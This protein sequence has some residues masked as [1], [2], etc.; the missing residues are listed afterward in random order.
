[1]K[2]DL[3]AVGQLIVTLILMGFAIVFMFKFP[4]HASTAV[5]FVGLLVIWDFMYY[6]DFEYFKFGKQGAVAKLNSDKDESHSNDGSSS[7]TKID[8]NKAFQDFQVPGLD[9]L[10]IGQY[11]TRNGLEEFS[12]LVRRAKLAKY[13]LKEDS[14]YL[15]NAGA[16]QNY[17]VEQLFASISVYDSK[18]VL[19]ENYKNY[20]KDALYESD[21]DKNRF[22][23]TQFDL[24]MQLGHKEAIKHRF[25]RAT[26]DLDKIS[27]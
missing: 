13:P 18:H 15:E 14:A 17:I 24:V 11:R 27:A 1:M 6:K 19:T 21:Y 8:F 23:A 12:R 2:W 16:F 22:L 5:I 4:E 25:E 26:S 9:V 7:N 20:L 10:L 3:K